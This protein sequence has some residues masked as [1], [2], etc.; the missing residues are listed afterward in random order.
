MNRFTTQISAACVFATLTL[1][2]QAQIFKKKNPTHHK[3]DKSNPLSGLNSKQPDKE[4]FDKAMNALKKGHFDVCRLDLQTLLNTYPDSEYQMRAKLAIGDSWFKEGGSAAY[5]QAESEYKDFITFFPNVPEA[6]EAQMKVA[7]IYYMQ[8]EKPDRDYTNVQRAE[9]EYRQ[10]INQFPDSTLVPR[11]KQR[12]R[13]VQEVMAQREFEIGTF[14]FTHENWAA[15]I[16][17][18]QTVADTYPLF[19]HSDLTLISLGDA[20][21]A[22]AR[23]AEGLK[24]PPAA[25]EQL[26]KIY[27]DQA[28]AAYDRVVTKYAMAPHVEDAKDRLIAIGRPVPE[29]TH[30]EL[31][32]SQAEEESHSAVKLQ[33]RAIM[34]FSRAPSTVE[35]VRVGEPTMADPP[36]TY[37]PQV[38]KATL[39]AFN[40]AIAGKTPAAPIQTAVSP[41]IQNGTEAPRSDQPAPAPQLENVPES[42]SGGNGV[43]AEII[44]PSANNGGAAAPPAEAPAGNPNG[45]APAAATSPT[46][47]V[48]TLIPDAGGLKSVGPTDTTSLPPVDKPAE[49]PT[50]VN[51]VKSSGPAQVTTGTSS[52]ATAAAKK[53]NRGKYDAGKESSSKHKK[54]KGVDKLNPF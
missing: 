18:L 15:T 26:V 10:M 32:E 48:P 33:Q 49:A 36:A 51:D 2:V 39:T 28:A 50:Q 9:Q 35:T 46:P 53:G 43:G 45:A 13:D 24:I 52:A 42:G 37:A 19:S 21:A 23:I 38:S 41:G 17:R 6:A 29:P 12:L 14:Y 25:K 27:N 20:Y 30:D 3:V 8:M 47:A 5:T 40:A 54:K 31:A 34:L 22:E 44:T 4:L 16:A 7:D 1:P 11:A